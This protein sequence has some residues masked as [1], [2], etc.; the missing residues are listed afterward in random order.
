MSAV[1]DG[2]GGST[3]YEPKLAAIVRELGGAVLCSSCKRFEDLDRADGI[4]KADTAVPQPQLQM[5]R[6][7]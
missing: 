1:C 3:A 6:S 2:C 7:K 4:W 5:E